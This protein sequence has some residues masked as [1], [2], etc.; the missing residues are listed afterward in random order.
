MSYGTD[1]EP[2][3]EGINAD[4]ANWSLDKD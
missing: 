4:I 2:G 3:G 1:G